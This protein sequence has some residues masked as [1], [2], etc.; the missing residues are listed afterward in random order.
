M[1]IRTAEAGYRPRENQ[2]LLRVE[3][4][5]FAA[6]A[7]YLFSTLGVSRGL[8]VAL[9]LVPDLSALG[10]MAGKETGA[11]TYNLFHL[12]VWPLAIGLA[13]YLIHIGSADSS[14]TVLAIGL[15]W[16]AHIGVDRALGYGLKQPDSVEVTHLGPIGKLKRSRSRSSAASAGV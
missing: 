8:F 10:F 1:P 9:A 14:P 11:R 3:G 15:I 5:A 6:I 12:W 13:G 7:I 2:I 16:A 4:A